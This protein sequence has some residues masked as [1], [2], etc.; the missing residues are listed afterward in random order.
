MATAYL[1][2]RCRVVTNIRDYHTG[3]IMRGWTGVIQSQTESCGRLVLL[4]YWEHGLT[5]SYVF[6][7]DIVLLDDP[8]VGPCV[9][10][11]TCHA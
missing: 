1:N 2:K 10:S 4:V 9:V 3:A 8:P 7:D 5:A 11:L 6:P